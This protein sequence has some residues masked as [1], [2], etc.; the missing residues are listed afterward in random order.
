M[1]SIYA[2]FTDYLKMY[3]AMIAL[4]QQGFNKDSISIYLKDKWEVDAIVSR[5]QRGRSKTKIKK[6]VEDGSNILGIE[7]G[8]LNIWKAKTLLEKAG[9]KKIIKNFF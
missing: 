9:G 2:T 8:I 4:K 6:F 7:T 1:S 3:D 5:L